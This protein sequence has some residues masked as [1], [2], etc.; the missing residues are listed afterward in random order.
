MKNS[1]KY[2]FHVKIIKIFEIPSKKNRMCKKKNIF[3]FIF[4]GRKTI[5]KKKKKKPSTL[6]FDLGAPLKKHNQEN[7]EKQHSSST[8]K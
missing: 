6:N 4:F 8:L 2:F 1:I 3:M 5:P 7:I